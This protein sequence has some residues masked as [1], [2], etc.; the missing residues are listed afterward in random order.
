MTLQ[1]LRD[2]LS[3]LRH[4]S[5]RAAARSQGVSQAGL[6]N[7]LRGLE[8]SLGTTLLVRGGRGVHPTPAGERLRARAMLIVAEADRA[9]ADA[10]AG[11]MPVRV[12]FSPTPGALLLPLVLPHFRQRQPE[13]DLRLTGGLFERLLPA[14]R[15]GQLDFAVLSLPEGGAG[16]GMESS[17][18]MKT[19]MAVVARRGHPMARAR[20]LEELASYEWVLMGPPE[21]PGGTAIRFFREVGLPPPRI[22]VS[23]DSFTQVSALLGSTDYLALLPRLVLE[24]ELLGPR[25]AEIA[26]RERARSY[27]VA[28][29]WRAGSPPSGPAAELASMLTS[30]ARSMGRVGGHRGRNGAG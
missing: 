30:C 12:G 1:Q 19:A 26:V 10:G 8:R 22:A 16:A 5:L 14:V 27:D 11:S 9:I 25:L 7:S 4:G 3:V 28:L 20:G 21:A 17:V 13:A 18:L 2:F 23:C 24:R 15:D 29:V 6:T